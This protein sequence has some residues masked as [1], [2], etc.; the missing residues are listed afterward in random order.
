MQAHQ[1]LRGAGPPSWGAQG[2]RSA[3]GL[4]AQSTVASRAAALTFR[5]SCAVESQ[6]TGH[7]SQ[8]FENYEPFS[9]PRQLRCMLSFKQSHFPLSLSNLPGNLKVNQGQVF[10]S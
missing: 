2:H 8:T 7:R 6:D 1:G 3:R 9:S 10:L 4:R 5:S